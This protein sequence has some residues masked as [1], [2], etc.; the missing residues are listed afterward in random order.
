MSIPQSDRAEGRVRDLRGAVLARL[1]DHAPLTDRLELVES[2][3]DGG[4]AVM[5]AFALD[6]Q[7]RSDGVEPPDVALAVMAVT[8]SS[9]RE[10]MQ[11]RKNHV[12]QTKLQL[13]A[14]AMRNR[15]GPWADA[16]LSEIAAV[17]TSHRD[18]FV[19]RGQ[20]GGSPDPTWNDQKRR[21]EMVQRFDIMHWG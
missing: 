20:T 3:T 11:E 14:E 21:Y 15:G 6:V 19:A 1:R 8:G 13:R 12:V 5:P 17:L 7:H 16:V 10:N 4:D 2:V 18:P 9:D